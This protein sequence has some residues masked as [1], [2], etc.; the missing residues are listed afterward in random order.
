[1]PDSFTLQTLTYF[2]DRTPVIILSCSRTCKE[3]L[4]GF[5]AFK[6][7]NTNNCN[8]DKTLDIKSNQV[9]S[10]LV[11]NYLYTFLF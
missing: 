10:C 4:Y 8:V 9:S 5:N 6:C 2:D 3:G 1:M 11:L 7:C